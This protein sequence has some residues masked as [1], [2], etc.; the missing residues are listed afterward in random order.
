MTFKAL[1]TVHKSL[2]KRYFQ[3]IFSMDSDFVRYAL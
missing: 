2:V 1:D 3:Q